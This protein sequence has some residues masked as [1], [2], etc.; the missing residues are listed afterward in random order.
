MS[1]KRGKESPK[2]STQKIVKLTRLLNPK[3]DEKLSLL[4]PAE[5]SRG[6]KTPDIISNQFLG[7]LSRWIAV[8]S[9]YTNR[10]VFLACPSFFFSYE[11]EIF[12]N[13]D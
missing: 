6:S 5:H 13:Q 9:K 1:L 11:M 8:S 3:L 12:L 2:K 10:L 7:Y 4:A